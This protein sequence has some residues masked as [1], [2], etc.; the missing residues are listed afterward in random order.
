M[1]KNLYLKVPTSM[2]EHTILNSVACKN[3]FLTLIY[4]KYLSVCFKFI[5][6]AF[7]QLENC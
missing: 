4:L 6:C 1:L 7:V 3:I 5:C 2:S